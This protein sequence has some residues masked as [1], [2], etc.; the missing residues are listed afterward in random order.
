MTEVDI[1]ALIGA[2]TGG[3][4]GLLS[5]RQDRINT[6]TAEL[7]KHPGV[8]D[9]PVPYNG[10]P[11]YR[12]IK[13]EPY[14]RVNIDPEDLPPFEPLDL[15]QETIRKIADELSDKIISRAIRSSRRSW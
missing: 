9:L 12:V 6:V 14:G 4:L 8:G 1:T 2:A 11:Q 5:K 10:F 13:V 3:I 15:D 7:P